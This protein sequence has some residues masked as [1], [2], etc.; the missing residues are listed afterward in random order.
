MAQQA[1]S[2]WRVELTALFPDRERCIEAFL[3]EAGAAATLARA[4]LLLYTRDDSSRCVH[5]LSIRHQRQLSFAFD[6]L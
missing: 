3:A 1:S 4:R 6:R 2:L 5:Q